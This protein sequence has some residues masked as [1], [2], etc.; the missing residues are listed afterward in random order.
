MRIVLIRH[1]PSAHP[2]ARGLLNRADVER[3][4]AAYDAAGIASH[5]PPPQPV[6]DLAVAADVAVA[7]DLPRG[8]ASAAQLW[9]GRAVT[10]SPLFR[11]IPLR[12]PAL[13]RVL[14]PFPVWS[15]AI[16]LQW[17]LDTLSGRDIPMGDRQ[18]VDEAA[19]WCEHACEE[20]G[21]D[22]VLAVVT[23]GAFR[24]ALARRLVTTAWQLSGS[25]RYAPW[26]VW[27]LARRDAPSR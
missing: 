1:G 6:L 26:S 14:A 16:H 5:L 27:T 17:G 21:A 24:R 22:A 11:E 18:R 19:A 10:Y 13:G 3:W 25:R 20:H 23:H 2:S 12:I 15:L 4:R 9:P 7:S 8:I